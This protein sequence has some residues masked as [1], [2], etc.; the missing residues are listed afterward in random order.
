MKVQADHELKPFAED[1]KFAFNECSKVLR[2]L[3]CKDF[4]QFIYKTLE[5]NNK[6][7]FLVEELAKNFSCLNDIGKLHD[8]TTIYFYK[9]AQLVVGELYRNLRKKEEK[10]NFPDINNMTV[11]VDNVLPA[12][13]MCDEILILDEE[14]R[15]KIDDGKEIK[16]GP[17]EAEIRSISIF[18]CEEIIKLNEKLNS[19]NLDYYLWKIGKEE[20]YR[21]YERHSTKNTI[22]Y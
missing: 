5:K 10:F 14:I 12:V 17:I 7:E 8:G 9:K 11:F 4:A 18:I 3:D 22:F 2:S 13:L 15:K 6:C 21:K 20:K 1:I 19:V 16:A